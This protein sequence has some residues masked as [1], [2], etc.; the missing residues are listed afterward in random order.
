[1]VAERR[2]KTPFF[3]VQPGHVCGLKQVAH[4]YAPDGEFL[5]LTFIAAL[6]NEREQDTITITGKPNLEVTLKGTNGDLATVAIAVNAIKRVP[7]PR[8]ASSPC[9]TC[10]SSPTG[11]R[12]AK[13]TLTNAKRA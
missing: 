6:D 7:T 5:T 13:Q 8:P 2:I 1:M 4:A 3:D 11:R 9:A 12:G 10:P